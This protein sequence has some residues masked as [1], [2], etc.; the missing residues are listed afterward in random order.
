M[1]SCE[2]DA[3]LIEL[4]AT[5]C[6]ADDLRGSGNC[7]VGSP[8]VEGADGA[9]MPEGAEDI[10]S[11]YERDVARDQG[12]ESYSLPPGI[13]AIRCGAPACEQVCIVGGIPSADAP[14]V[15]VPA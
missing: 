1:G 11:E 12:V 10:T 3:T 5:S 8:F 4:A 14:M 6:N 13:R 15:P 9:A 2:G 7:L